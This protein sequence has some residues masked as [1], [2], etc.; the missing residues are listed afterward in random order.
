ME[1]DETIVQLGD[2]L[3][4]WCD[5]FFAMLDSKDRVAQGNALLGGIEIVKELDRLK[6]KGLAAIKALLF[7]QHATEDERVASLVRGFEFA[8]KLRHTLSDELMD[9]DGVNKTVDLTNSIADALDATSSGRAALAVL[10][11]H[12]DARVRASA[13]AYLANSMPERVIP[14]LRAIEEHERGNS[15]HFTA[16]WAV[17]DWE[18]KE[19]AGNRK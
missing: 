16:H 9:T 15:A 3:D 17:L 10:L 13:G 2:R 8:A 7:R 12:S 19:Q 14:I 11:D 18:L 5:G 1:L 6:A 4:T